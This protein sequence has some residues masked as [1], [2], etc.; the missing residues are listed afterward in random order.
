MNIL[1]EYMESEEWKATDMS[2]VYT[3]FLVDDMGLSDD[4]YL[5]T[6]AADKMLRVNSPKYYKKI[7]HIEKYMRVIETLKHYADGEITYKKARNFLGGEVRLYTFTNSKTGK[8]TTGYSIKD[9]I[10]ANMKI[11]FR[12]LQ[13]K[14]SKYKNAMVKSGLIAEADIREALKAEQLQIEGVA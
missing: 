6:F 10:D 5:Q 9:Q 3:C 7:A 12:F 2:M 4:E 13:F 8:S 11:L 14:D 1:D